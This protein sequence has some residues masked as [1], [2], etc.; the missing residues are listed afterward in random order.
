M[1][2]IELE[3]T[4][5]ERLEEQLEELEDD[6]ESRITWFTGTGVPKPKLFSVW[7]WEWVYGTAR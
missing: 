1:A 4:G 3:T 2:N 7:D 5:F 6:I